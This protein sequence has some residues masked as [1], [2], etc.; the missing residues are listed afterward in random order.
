MA[1][2][3]K[4]FPF[5]TTFEKKSVD[6]EISAVVNPIRI[7][8]I[9]ALGIDFH[10]SL[11]SYVT[12]SRANFEMAAYDFERIIEAVDTDSFVKQAFLKYKELFFKE[13]WE[14]IGENPDAINYLYQRID[15]IEEVMDRPF[16]DY[17][18]EVV[19]NLVKFSNTFIVISRGNIGPYF[20]GKLTP[21]DGELPIAGFYTIPT[22]TVR[23]LRNKY[24]RPLKYK[25]SLVDLPYS[26]NNLVDPIFDVSEVIHLYL[27][28]KPGRAFGTPFVVGVLDDVI[29]LRQLEEDVQ[30]LIHKEL[31]PL[32][33]YKVGTDEDPALPGDVEKA[34]EQLANLRVE[35]GL[36]IPNTHDVEVIGSEG[37]A[38][39][40]GPYME[41]MRQR[42]IAGL[43]IAP[44]HLGIMSAGGNK[45]VTDRL[46]IALY[47]KIKVLQDYVEN[48]IRL[49][50]LNP[51]LREGGFD[52]SKNPRED[53]NSDRCYMV[54][55]E[56]DIDTQIKKEN[57]IIQKYAQNVIDLE[58][59]RLKLGEDAEYDMGHMMM[60][61][62]AQVQTISQMAVQQQ[63]A[64]LAPV[65]S[66]TST[67]ATG[68]KSTSTT[69]PPAGL[70]KPQKPDAQN[71][72]TGILPNM[73]NKTKGVGNK[74]KPANQHGRR[75][76]PNIR[77]MD[78]DILKTIVELI[79]DEEE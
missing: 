47:D 66:K 48:A 60:T 15:L 3:R 20:P 68:G 26:T 51:L 45:S 74:D 6:K 11:S 78:D 46:D 35:G 59:T 64:A 54:F 58:E 67:T 4:I 24:N 69:K 1:S 61:L 41:M 30:N 62:T 43:G 52:L 49:Y 13:G 40:A 39:D 33:K 32:Y 56:I 22:E 7:M 27:D 17:L 25:Q 77:H 50:V 57:H 5:T 14:I 53:G 19:D 18:I 28:K 42:V 79:D 76:S 2:F 10:N 37:K 29:A 36:I 38:L 21:P 44:H 12:P 34:A 65:V 8:K 73:P 72:S 63:A 23:I 9:R 71:P 55:K 70:P 31:F 75:M 16:N